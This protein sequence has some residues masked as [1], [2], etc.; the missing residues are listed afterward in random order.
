MDSAAD[1]A[2]ANLVRHEKLAPENAIQGCLAAAERIRALGLRI[3][4]ADVLV[5]QGRVPAGRAEE[6]RRLQSLTS[7]RP[8]QRNEVGTVSMTPEEDAQ[9][10]ALAVK[11]LL[12]PRDKCA[13]AEGLVRQVA[14]LGCR[15]RLTEVLAER[16]ALLPETVFALLHVLRLP[17]GPAGSGED[18]LLY[19]AVAVQNKLATPA[20]AQKALGVQVRLAKTT[21]VRQSVGELLVNQEVMRVEDAKR[22]LDILRLRR[23]VTAIR[24]VRVVQLSDAESDRIEQ[25]LLDNAVITEEVFE[26]CQVLQRQMADVGVTKKIGEILIEK[27]YIKRDALDAAEGILD[28]RKFSAARLLAAGVPEEVANRSLRAGAGVGTLVVVLLVVALVVFRGHSTKRPG[29][30]GTGDGGAGEV[31]VAGDPADWEARMRT[32]EARLLSEDWTGA[33]RELA[34][35]REATGSGARRSRADR[36]R[37]EAEAMDGMCRRLEERFAADRA[38]RIPVQFDD[39][40]A[41]E[42]SGA[43]RERVSLRPASEEAIQTR[44]WRELDARDRVALHLA[45]GPAESEW[46]ALACFCARRGADLP[47]EVVNH[48]GRGDQADVDALA[49]GVPRLA[50]RA[51]ADRVVPAEAAFSPGAAAVPLELGPSGASSSG[52]A[53]AAAAGPVDARLAGA[54]ALAAQSALLERV[55]ERLRLARFEEARALTAQWLDASPELAS[56]IWR[57]CVAALARLAAFREQV[58]ARVASAEKPIAA[59]SLP[60][61]E[62]MEGRLAALTPDGLS[63]RLGGGQVAKGWKELPVVAWKVL[64]AVVLP[65]E[66]ERHVPLALLFLEAGDLD[67]SRREWEQAARAAEDVASIAAWRSA[68]LDH[69]ALVALRGSLDEAG[70]MMEH[71]QGADALDRLAG[72]RAPEFPLPVADLERMAVLRERAREQCAAEAAAE[73]TKLLSQGRPEDALAAVEAAATRLG[74]APQA[75][76]LAET[77]AKC[78]RAV[79]WLLCGWD[80]DADLARWKGLGGQVEVA[81]EA[82]RVRSAPGALHWVMR[83]AEE[84]GLALSMESADLRSYEG[85][86]LWVRSPAVSLCEFEVRVLSGAGDYLSYPVTL[87]KADATDWRVPFANFRRV[88][89]PNLGAVRELRLVHASNAAGGEAYLDDLR[90]VHR[91]ASPEIASVPPKRG[92]PESGPGSGAGAGPGAGGGPAGGGGAAA[93]GAG[94]G[95]GKAPAEPARPRRAGQGPRK[96]PAA[97][98]PDGAYYSAEYGIS[99]IP[100]DHWQTIP[101]PKEAS[102]EFRVDAAIKTVIRFQSRQPDPENFA[103]NLD[104]LSLGKADSLDEA[105]N[106]YLA[107]EKE[108]NSKYEDPP[109]RERDIV[110]RMP[111]VWFQLAADRG[112]LESVMIVQGYG[113]GFALAF[114]CGKKHGQRKAE[115]F[116][117]IARTF[118]F[119]ND[120]QIDKLLARKGGGSLGPGWSSFTTAHYEIQYN[121]DEEFA[122]ELG[123]HLEAILAEYQ[124]RFPM[125]LERAVGEGGE[126]KGYRRFT[127]K[128]FKTEQEFASYAAQNGVTGAAAYFSP[129][130]NELVAYKTV[131][132]GKRKTFHILYH[133]ASHQYMYL[134]LGGDV[135]IP[136][137]LNEGVAE[138]FYGAEFGSDGRFSIGLNRERVV[139]IKDAV[140]QGKHVPL[141]KLFKY[142]QTQYYANPE[143]CYAEG[144]A[145]SYFLWTTQDPRYKGVINKFYD[146]LKRLKD[147]QKAFDEGFAGVDIEQLQADWEK[148]VSTPGA[149]R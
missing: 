21:G 145:L 23:P 90:V 141:A 103:I 86:A 74:D 49:A 125:D 73:A 28:S 8:I 39:G 120:D 22:V 137:W 59:S 147:K 16:G 68:R 27:G 46:Y 85:V 92:G 80:D 134:Y 7:I 34:A 112:F 11:Y 48:L 29:A 36:R 31:D 75:V 111:A 1:T 63:I 100:P 13:E 84:G 126:A 149:M 144:W 19:A 35:L 113:E 104:V 118:A 9:A 52:A 66:A 116:R 15:V 132:E 110:G 70:R 107:S 24:P 121:G 12:V 108:H 51:S 77:R 98:V 87:S 58:A 2:F 129:A 119:L 99:L 26:E 127:V 64:A 101:P 25:I 142:S 67:G 72:A 81:T 96:G 54:L 102:A 71:G 33:I 88:G 38:L 139:P 53:A 143:V 83:E 78:R 10:A 5:D 130:Q 30:T 128:S 55:A 146:A 17:K 82:D 4:V 136:I 89:S 60:G 114:S 42:L 94:K 43:T 135:E 3:G 95:P 37:N 14:Q 91:V 148:W 41:W 32:A 123:K 140:R 61:L 40:R 93:G 76:R 50:P 69:L 44:A 124:R 138:Y 105:V 56:P 18:E 47:V 133:E 106:T 109:K 97:P 115:E 45:A 20:Q 117:R 79:E 6:L 65:K 57:A 122:R 62:A 131:D